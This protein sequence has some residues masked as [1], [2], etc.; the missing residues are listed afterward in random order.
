M[1]R[2]INTLAKAKDVAIDFEAVVTH[3]LNETIYELSNQANCD[4]LV[5]GWK[6]KAHNGILINNPIGWLMTHINSDFALFKDNGVRYI[7]R[8]LLALRPGRKDKNFIAI[9]DRICQFY[10][11]SFTLLHVIPEDTKSEEV[12]QMEAVSNKLLLKSTSISEL[13]ILKSNNSIETISKTSAD[14]DL[15]IL[16]TPEKNNWMNVLFGTGK[17]KFADSS[18]CSVLR[19]TMKE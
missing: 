19:L 11:A 16:G 4:W 13:K 2:R 3:N 14:Y 1:K 12:E 7:S 18:A 17:D 5:V 10:N 9:A 8:V 15:L 6:G